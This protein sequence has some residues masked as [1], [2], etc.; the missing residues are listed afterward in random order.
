MKACKLKTLLRSLTVPLLL[1]CVPLSI[2][3]AEQ[4]SGPRLEKNRLEVG[5][6]GSGTTSLP[7]FVAFEGGYFAK[8][9]LA[10][11][12]SQVGATVAVQGVISET[13]YIYQGGTAAAPQIWAAP[14]SSTLLPRSIKI[15]S[16]YSGKKESRHSR[17]CAVNRSQRLFPV[18]S[19]KSPC[20]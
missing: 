15:R 18:R 5:T 10:V 7:L 17:H 6:A 20:A 11:S 16:F 4:P 1:I 9:G 3:S 12:I 2:Q 19:A 8:R 14:I 13:L